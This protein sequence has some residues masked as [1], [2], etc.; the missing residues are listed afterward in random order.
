MTDFNTFMSIGMQK[1]APTGR[2]T[3]EARRETFS[4]LVDVWNAEEETIREMD[5]S[6][7][8]QNL[9]CP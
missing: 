1:C 6:E 7:V 9:N 3:V 2:G 5:P 4:C 8:R